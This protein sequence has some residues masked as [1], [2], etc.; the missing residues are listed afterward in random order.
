I[1]AT[2]LVSFVINETMTKEPIV[3]LRVFKDRSF[4][5]GCLTQFT[6]FFAFFGSVV[7]L[8][9]YVQRLMGYT[10]FLAGVV[11]GPAAVINLLIFP[12]VGRLIRFVDAR[13]LLSFGILGNALALYL[14]AHF[15]LEVGFWNIVW[16]RVIQAVGL[17]FF[18]VPL[19][20][21]TFIEIKKEEIGNATA[22]YNL[23]RNLGASFGTSVVATILS[24]RAQ[25]HQS[26]LTEHLTPSDLSFQQ[27][28]EGL[29]HIL[30][31]GFH[32]IGAIYNELL[33]QAL[34]MAFNDAFFFCGVLFI[35]LLSSL[36]VL[37]KAKGL[38]A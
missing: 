3:N 38:S 31:S 34:M 17:A 1:S 25:F 28:Y 13:Y 12:I 2:A 20:T 4:S 14:M 6:G 15:N 7:L 22:V 30:P 23:L 8:T 29:R 10:A 32:T 5:I 21:V 24:R 36:I 18:F 9:L 19:A 35:L 11:F 27:Y 33:R 16:L 37:K 26:R